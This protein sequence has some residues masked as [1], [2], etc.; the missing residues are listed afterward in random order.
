MKRGC[1]GDLATM[2]ASHDAYLAQEA[3]V[4]AKTEKA[5]STIYT[6]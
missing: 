2:Q 4:K 3:Q 5:E 1:A 6:Y